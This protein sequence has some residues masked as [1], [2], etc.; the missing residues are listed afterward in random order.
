MVLF[1]VIGGILFSRFLKKRAEN[2]IQNFSLLSVWILALFSFTHIWHWTH[3]SRIPQ[4]GALIYILL[5]VIIYFIFSRLKQ[6]RERKKVFLDVKTAA[7]TVVFV[8][9]LSILLFYIYFN[10]VS[11]PMVQ[12]DSGGIALR[13]GI[14]R[15]VVGTDRSEIYPPA[16]QAMVYSKIL[17]YIEK[18]TS[19]EDRILCFGES[20][21]YF[22]SKR[23]NATE[24]DNGRIPGYFPKKRKKFLAQ[25][26]NNKPEIIIFRQWEFKFWSPKM[27]DVIDFITSNYFYDTKIFNFYIFSSI[28]NASKYIKEGNSY[29]WK[30]QI[31]KSASAYL[32]AL[33][34]QNQNSDIHKIL[35]RFFSNNEIS[36]RA[37][38][39][40]EGYYV[41]KTRDLW[42]LRWGSKEKQGFS[43]RI[44]LAD[45][46]KMERVTLDVHPYPRGEKSVILT[47]TE[48]T[49]EYISGVPNNIGGFDITFPE[50]HPPL[51]ARF[52]LYIGGK[53]IERVFISARGFIDVSDTFELRK[54]A[55]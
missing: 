17:S 40:L 41:Q 3:E 25:I 21:L 39:V 19:P 48:N 6:M 36:K 4:S 20:P 27:P 50:T 23:K 44:V 45:T 8:M 24:F 9:C 32:K 18:N 35:N 14:H 33:E 46:K 31:E 15:E 2:K 51:S 49:I 7:W 30:N 22:L 10:F 26:K 5:A 13:S 54:A 38:S 53:K 12:Y 55:K 43:G 11:H 37:L 1:F 16:R 52:D 29:F 34:I 47:Q 42:R 28:D